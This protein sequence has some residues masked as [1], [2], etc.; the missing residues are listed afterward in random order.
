[1]RRIT[2]ARRHR[3]CRHQGLAPLFFSVTSSLFFIIPRGHISIVFSTQVE[4][5]AQAHESK[6]TSTSFLPFPIPYSLFPFFFF[7]YHQAKPTHPSPTDTP[8]FHPPQVVAPVGVD[9]PTPHRGPVVDA[10]RRR[11]RFCEN[12]SLYP[13]RYLFSSTPPPHSEMKPSELWSSVIKT[14]QQKKG[15]RT[16]CC[17]TPRPCPL[18]LAKIDRRSSASVGSLGWGGWR[19]R[20]PPPTIM[21]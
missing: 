4:R 12:C 13:R 11:A 15:P 6:R 9:D 2:L 14:K 19:G 5:E 17:F 16:G 8:K 20:A 7:L 3:P 1:M 10:G 21:Y 18:L